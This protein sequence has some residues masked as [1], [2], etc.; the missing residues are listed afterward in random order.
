MGRVLKHYGMKEKLSQF[1]SQKW[2]SLPY[3]HTVRNKKE[4]IIQLVELSFP[5][6]LAISENRSTRP[7]D[8]GG[9]RTLGLLLRRQ[10]LYPAELPNQPFAKGIRRGVPVFAVQRYSLWCEK[11]NNC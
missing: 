11:Q 3:Q 2:C 5:N 6:P 4:R 8:S 9:T 7:C 1:F 10:L